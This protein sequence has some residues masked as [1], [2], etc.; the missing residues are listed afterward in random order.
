VL[1]LA[2]AAG[3]ERA[4]RHPVEID[5]TTFGVVLHEGA[6][7]ELPVEGGGGPRRIV[8]PA[9]GS[10]AFYLRAPAD[11]RLRFAVQ[12]GTPSDAVDVHAAVGPRETPLAVAAV[13]DGDR[14]A[15]LGADEGAIVRLRL[16]NRG[17]APLTWWAPR[18]TGT[19][20]ARPAILD[21]AVRPPPGPLNVV[22]LVVDA[23]RADHASLY[24][25]HRATTPELARLAAAHGVV[26]EQAY[27]TGPS[28][29]NSIPSLFAARPPSALGM[30]FRGQSG[31]ARRTLTELLG[32]GGMRTA[33]FV[34][35]PLLIGAFGYGRGF[36]TYE[37]L[38]LEG[39]RT[40]FV[41]SDLLVDRAL[42]FLVVN[43]DAPCFVYLHAMETHTPFDPSTAHR[44]RFAGDGTTRPP[45]PRRAAD[46]RL[47]IDAA[48]PPRPGPWAPADLSALADAIDP[49]RYDEAIASVDEQIGRLV[50]GIEA[51]GVGART[52]LVVTADHG[53]ALGNE[54]DGRFLHGHALYEELVH[55]PLVLV[56][57]WLDGAHRVREVVSLLDLA[58][59]LVDL[60]GMANA[61]GL[62]GASWLR[63]GIGVDPPEAL[64]E[65]LAE[66][67]N[68]GA[69]R[70]RG[71]FGVAEWGIRQDVWKLIMDDARVR[72]FHLPSDPKETRDVSATHPEM[73]GY[74][75]GRVARLSP[76]L[77]RFGE[78]PASIDPAGGAD[79]ELTEALR[80]LGYIQ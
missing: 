7:R 41:R 67:W 8:Q 17:S 33:A 78:A 69:V 71:V 50:R 56:L 64:L 6:P 57:P 46:G 2:G 13:S 72:L 38:R 60:A 75:A 27:A 21:A 36:E 66:P 53:E 79:R 49:E 22:I 80:A 39:S 25:Y 26:F 37:I 61:D 63:P 28:T 3:C 74:L 15:R 14:E 73:T 58:P 19:A 51:L 24:G 70:G 65:R 68:A 45:T 29:P 77:G 43:R 11:A 10:F 55:V 62:G 31:R 4:A 12:P 52:L 30:N 9:G 42:E 23:L 44:G 40:G 34:A 32:L 5:L 35:N 54:D 47:P 76:G 18:V 1:L 20:R 59:T 48:P 16:A